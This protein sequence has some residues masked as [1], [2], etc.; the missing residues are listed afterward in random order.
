MESPTNIVTTPT[1]GRAKKEKSTEDGS[2]HKTDRKRLWSIRSIPTRNQQNRIMSER[3]T[4]WKKDAGKKRKAEIYREAYEERGDT[5]KKLLEDLLL[6][7]TEAERE[8]M[9]QKARDPARE[10]W[11]PEEY[12]EI[13]RYSQTDNDLRTKLADMDKEGNGLHRTDSNGDV[14]GDQ[15][16]ADYGMW[17][18]EVPEINVDKRDWEAK[19][20]L[21]P[22]DGPSSHDLVDQHGVLYRGLFIPQESPLWDKLRVP[23]NGEKKHFW[24]DAHMTRMYKKVMTGRCVFQYANTKKNIQDDPLE[25]KVFHEGDED[26]WKENLEKSKILR[27][28]HNCWPV[29]K[30]AVPAWGIGDPDSKAFVFPCVQCCSKDRALS[31]GN[32]WCGAVLASI[33]KGRHEKGDNPELKLAGIMKL[34]LK[35]DKFG[36]LLEKKEGSLQTKQMLAY[37]LR[38]FIHTN[39]SEGNKNKLALI[40]TDQRCS[41]WNNSGGC[42]RGIP[43]LCLDFQKF[44]FGKWEGWELK[45]EE[46][47]QMQPPENRM[48]SRFSQFVEGCL[49]TENG[50]KNM[51]SEKGQIKLCLWMNGKTG[52]ATQENLEIREKEKKGHNNKDAGM[53]KTNSQNEG[54]YRRYRL[55]NVITDFACLVIVKEALAKGDVFSRDHPPVL[56]EPKVLFKEWNEGEVMPL[57]KSINMHWLS[58]YQLLGCVRA[59]L[60]H[61]GACQGVS[62]SQKQVGKGATTKIADFRLAYVWS[63]NDNKKGGT[64]KLWPMAGE[65]ALPQAG[66]GWLEHCCDVTV[67]ECDEKSREFLFDVV[68]EKAVG[69]IPK[70]EGQ[71]FGGYKMKPYASSTWTL[72]KVDVSHGRD[73]VWETLPQGDKDDD[74][75]ETGLIKLVVKV[76]ES[77]EKKTRGDAMYWLWKNL[78]WKLGEEFKKELTENEDLNKK[79]RENKDWN[80]PSAATWILKYH[81]T[82]MQSR[83]DTGLRVRPAP[84]TNISPD[85]LASMAKAGRF[86]KDYVIPGKEGIW[87]RLFKSSKDFRG[88]LIKIQ[89]GTI[90]GFPATAIREVGRINHIEGN[91]HYVVRVVATLV[92]DGHQNVTGGELGDKLY[93]PHLEKTVEKL[94]MSL[95]EGEA[96]GKVPEDEEL[97]EKWDECL[98]T[99]DVT[100]TGYM[101]AETEVKEKIKKHADME[102]F[103]T[104][105]VRA[106]DNKLGI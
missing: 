70:R 92:R 35:L 67:M 105:E 20:Q 58:F 89:P 61:G 78:Q 81:V 30:G 106:F 102:L 4:Q 37:Y 99:I 11:V 44:L 32:C 42:Q 96:G 45:D 55:R 8:E 26:F 28:L 6:K 9:R 84:H 22:N 2:A 74:F 54:C 104:V 75:S 10:R 72:L 86:V 52:E 83:F 80:I 66:G 56:V 16:H 91:P 63:M 65:K 82:Y 23:L 69:P 13:L 73:Q 43:A 94:K 101:K 46:L 103:K 15:L 18:K 5:R 62:D 1:T 71:E 76:L 68:A 41:V 40:G 88:R 27:L 95:V 33:A 85:E 29:A 57:T 14:L 21:C 79:L 3:P 64:N 77:C 59:I 39:V 51:F 53:E 48:E 17:L 19:E 60:G 49:Q 90:L 50:R 47:N 24:K 38:N 93:Y 7:Q 97:G 100:K 87:Y 98:R 12:R 25:K 31:T 34:I 36:E